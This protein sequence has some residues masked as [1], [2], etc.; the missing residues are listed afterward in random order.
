MGMN[1]PEGRKLQNSKSTI[2][3]EVRET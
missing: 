1:R 2:Q 3:E